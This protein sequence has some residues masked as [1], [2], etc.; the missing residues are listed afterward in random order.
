MPLSD[1]CR[2]RTKHQAALLNMKVH[3]VRAESKLPCNML[4]AGRPN[5]RES[6]SSDAS[7]FAVLVSCRQVV[8]IT[9]HSWQVLKRMRPSPCVRVHAMRNSFVRNDRYPTPILPSDGSAVPH[10][11]KPHNKENKKVKAT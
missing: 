3:D 6:S 9:R 2:E 7:R 5:V 4:V 1:D 11:F 8:N 10:I